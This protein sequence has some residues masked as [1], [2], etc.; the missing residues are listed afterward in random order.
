MYILGIATCL[1]L[2][3][4][5]VFAIN[6]LTSGA[7]T[8]KNYNKEVASLSKENRTMEAQVADSGLLDQIHVTVNQL[9]FEKTSEIKYVEIVGTSV[10]SAR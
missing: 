2:S 8:I 3:V 9:G 7:Y 5:Y 6:Q 10:A 1:L 4:F